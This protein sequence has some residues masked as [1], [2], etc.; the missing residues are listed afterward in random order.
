MSSF[1]HGP[2]SVL[3]V[4]LTASGVAFV[5][6]ADADPS[7]ET[8][9]APD[10]SLVV[11][12][13]AS[14]DVIDAGL[15]AARARCDAGDATCTS[16][17]LPCS[18]TDFCPVTTPIAAHYAVNAVW[19]SS[20]SSVWFVGSGGTIARWDG[21]SFALEP[22]ATTYTLNAIWGSGPENVWAVSTPDV[23]LR[24]GASGVWEKVTPAE[25][26]VYRIQSVLFRTVWGP[27]DGSAVFAGGDRLSSGS[28]E[29]QIW[30]SS[31][32][33]V[34]WTGLSEIPQLTVQGIWGS[35][36]DDVWAVGFI[37]NTG[38]AAFHRI[39]SKDM[40]NPDWTMT[41]IQSSTVLNS[42]WGSGPNDVWAV[43]RQGT[44][45]H[46]T[47][48]A[49]RWDVVDS[50]TTQDL[51]AVWGTGPSDVWIAG[52]GGTLLHWDGSKWRRLVASY[53]IGKNPNLYGI[54]ASG[55]TDVWA[56]GASGTV[57][58]SSGVRTPEGDER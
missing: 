27:R 12:A 53:P 39:A 58:H 36:P 22:P 38:G 55:P 49:A 47:G 9:T 8:P 33:K 50:P 18:I 3:A 7:S 41:D 21:S 42:V 40:D 29:I 14:A 11:P 45:R 34:A 24:R 31:T 25:T 15:D 30:R 51:N 48:G 6:C 1:R 35:S 19:G 5:C 43:G 17:E 56:V 44:I 52:D 16:E 54:W 28:P 13:D 20:A 37:G 57:L 4:T 10:A 26:A 32:A 2:T 23:I 46:Y